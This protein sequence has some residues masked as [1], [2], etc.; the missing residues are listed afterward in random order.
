MTHPTHLIAGA[1]VGQITGDY[2][3]S[4][5]ISVI[6]DVDHIPSMLYHRVFRSKK[7]LFSSLVRV[8]VPHEARRGFFHNIVAFFTLSILCSKLF[9]SIA[10]PFTLS[11]LV[12]LVLDM[13]D[14][15]DTYI[16]Y[17]F[18]KLNIKGPIKFFSLREVA[19]ALTLLGIFV[20]ALIF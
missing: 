17:P 14:N 5:I 7:R 15:A 18:S 20:T 13:L 2:T 12:H 4:L 6:V 10:F 9:P 11:Y 1:L 16:F 8:G 3:T 19:F